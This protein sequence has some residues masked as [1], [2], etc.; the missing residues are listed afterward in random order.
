MML[1]IVLRKSCSNVASVTVVS[2]VKFEISYHRQHTKTFKTG[3]SLPNSGVNQF[4][5]E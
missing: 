5:M 3:T 1:V 4:Q 2:S